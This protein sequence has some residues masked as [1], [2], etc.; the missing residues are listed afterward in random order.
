MKKVRIQVQLFLDEE[1]ALLKKKA[2]DALRLSIN[3][4]KDVH[5]ERKSVDARKGAVKFLYTLDVGMPD[6]VPLPEGV[7]SAPEPLPLPIRIGSKK[8]SS[9]PVVIGA[10]PCGLFAALM[11]SEEG[12][13]PIVLERG[14]DVAK[15]KAQVERFFAGGAHDA[16]NNVLFG[17]GGAGAFSD[18]KL[19]ARGRDEYG[20][21]VLEALVDHGA[22]E[23]ILYM[24]KPHL[25][26]D[27]LTGIIQNLK[28]RIVSLGAQWHNDAKVTGFS[29]KDGRLTGVNYEQGGQRQTIPCEC[30]ILAIGHSA[31]DT[32]E[33][34]LKA[35]VALSFKPFAVGL[36]IEHP[37][38]LIDEVQYG[39]FA[40]HEKLGA[41]DY[42]LTAKHGDR[43]VY[44]FC[45]CP[46]G[47]VI[48]SISE[49]SCLCVNGMSFHKRDGENANAAVVVQVTQRDCG[50]DALSGIRF[51]RQFEQK[52]YSLGKDYSAPVQTLSG[53]LQKRATQIGQVKPSYPRGT[54]SAN[55]WDCLPVFAAEGIAAG[56]AQFDNQL[57][58]YLYRDALFTGVEMRTSSPVRILRTENR[59]SESF[60]GLYPAG[61][62][63]GYA[64][65]IVS[66]AA[67]G[68][69]SALAIMQEYAP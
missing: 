60:H 26:T 19:T 51:Q 11:L 47:V 40:G 59:Q 66:A 67:D 68:V 28:Q 56:V 43:G 29:Q 17:D 62:G 61:E 38:R 16:E 21:W 30:A 54:V 46:G 53:F 7:K 15:R 32:Y 4:I 14:G 22:P 1:E 45:M 25:G 13:N 42:A 2:A 24:N 37:Q 27:V 34:L 8:L 35:G 41:A 55:L 57:R 10:G 18:G 63:A 52:A 5:I 3:T 65:G 44:T 9:P 36:R 31:R 64:G 12:Y 6:D 39:K 48:P 23:E 20:T 49:E 50:T 33:M 69:K 58:G